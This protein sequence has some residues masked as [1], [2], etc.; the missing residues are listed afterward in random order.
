M[1]LEGAMLSF[2]LPGLGQTYYGKYLKGIIFFTSAVI[3]GVIG[4][5]FFKF[6]YIVL[7]VTLTA[8]IDAFS[9]DR[10]NEEF[11]KHQEEHRSELSEAMKKAGYT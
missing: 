5:V 1:G 6:P 7:I 4:E 9:Y 2:F 11:K 10:K 3:V 8:V